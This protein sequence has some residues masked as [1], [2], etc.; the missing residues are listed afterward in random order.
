MVWNRIGV[1]WQFS[2]CI[3]ARVRVLGTTVVAEV[4]LYTAW[5]QEEN[6]ALAIVVRSN[7]TQ[8]NEAILK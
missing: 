2:L 5:S 3:D 4:E 1:L 8:A 7:N 6:N